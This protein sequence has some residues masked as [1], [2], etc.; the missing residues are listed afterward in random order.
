MSDSYIRSRSHPIGNGKYLDPDTGEKKTRKKYLYDSISDFPPSEWELVQRKTW[1]Y[2]DSIDKE[3]QI[4]QTFDDGSYWY[5][6][7]AAGCDGDEDNEWRD[8]ELKK[9]AQRHS[10]CAA[11]AHGSLW[12]LRYKDKEGLIESEIMVSYF[13]EHNSIFF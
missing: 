2:Q 12:T 11:D 4:I 6:I 10:N 13:K 7:G 9:A 1:E 5:E 3:D 8:K